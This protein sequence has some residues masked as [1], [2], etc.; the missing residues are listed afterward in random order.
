M[1]KNN[2]HKLKQER[3]RLDK[4]KLQRRWNRLPQQS[5]AVSIL[6]L[7]KTWPNAPWPTWSDLRGGPVFNYITTLPLP[8]CEIAS[9]GEDVSA[10]R[11]LQRWQQ[12]SLLGFPWTGRIWSCRSTEEGTGKNFT[13]GN[14]NSA[15][16]AE[17]SNSKR[18]GWRGF[19][20]TRTMDTSMTTLSWR[21]NDKIQSWSWNRQNITQRVRYQRTL[22]GKGRRRGNEGKTMFNEFVM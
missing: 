15:E 14:I 6:Q 11:W 2:R 3:F 1:T 13:I 12:L 18:L 10:G 4:D 16:R 8:L 5:C 9:D 7:F 19:S 22:K 20:K 21:I 17:E